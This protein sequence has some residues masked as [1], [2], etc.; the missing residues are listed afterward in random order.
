MILPHF[1]LSGMYADICKFIVSEI[2]FISNSLGEYSD[3]SNLIF[4]AYI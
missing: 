1:S 4:L 2:A 3:M